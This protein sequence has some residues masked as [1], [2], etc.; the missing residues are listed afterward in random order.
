M[1]VSLLTNTATLRR[2]SMG[3][4]SM[5]EYVEGTASDTIISCSM[6]PLSGEHLQA[7]PEGRRAEDFYTIYTTEPL[8]TAKENV[9]NA[10]HIIFGGDTYVVSKV[11][12]WE[13]GFLNHYQAILERVKDA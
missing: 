3:A 4:R 1:P 12:Q 10:D 9:R 2:F 7:L 5:G 13:A 6:Q 8:Q 11:M